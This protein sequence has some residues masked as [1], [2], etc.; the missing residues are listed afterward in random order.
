MTVVVKTP[1]F[2]KKEELLLD[3]TPTRVSD[4]EGNPAEA[5]TRWSEDG[6]ALITTATAVGGPASRVTLTRSLA[7]DRRTTYL[8]LDYRFAGKEP[9]RV[10][11]VFRLIRLA[12]AGT[13]P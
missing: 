5:V 9:V 4:P 10:R 8:D 13:K 6:Q 12:D 7:P 1:L 3:G 11:R 2:E